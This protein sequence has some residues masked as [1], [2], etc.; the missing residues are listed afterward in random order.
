MLSVMQLLRF[1]KGSLVE[2]KALLAVI[3]GDDEGHSIQQR[4]MHFTRVCL[5]T[6]TIF[7]CVSSFLLKPFSLSL[8]VTSNCPSLALSQE[9]A[10]SLTTQVTTI[11]LLSIATITMRVAAQLY[12]LLAFLVTRLLQLPCLRLTCA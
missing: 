7:H 4:A 6:S 9:S 5:Y 8:P 3:L 10:L 11:F 12:M 2:H 1:S